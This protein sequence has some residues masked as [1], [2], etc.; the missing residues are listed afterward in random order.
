[1]KIAEL[2]NKKIAIIGFGVEGQAAA[3]FLRSRGLP[4]AILDKTAKLEIPDDAVRAELGEQYLANLSDYDVIIRSPGIQPF[5]PEFVEFKKRGGIIETQTRLFFDNYAHPERII[6]VTGTKGK[7]TTSILIQNILEQAKMPVRLAGN[8]GADMLALLNNETVAENPW[9]V[10]ELS[11]FQLQDCEASPHIA[12]VLMV[13]S[14][15]LDYHANIQEYVAA[16]ASIGRY[17]TP[18]D[19]I[20]INADYPSS[21][22]IGEESKAQKYLFST[23]TAA[24][25]GDQGATSLAE[26]GEIAFI[27]NGQ[28]V[29]LGKIS[30]LKLRGHHN[31]QNVCAAALV[32]SLVGVSDADIWNA[33]CD[34]AGYAHRLQLVHEENGVQFFDDSIA[35]VP[36]SSLTA[37]DSFP[38]PVILFVGGIDKGQDYENLGKELAARKSLKAVVA[39]GI[40]GKRIVN[41]LV[42]GGFSGK[43]ITPLEQDASAYDTA[44][45]E[46][47]TIVQAGDVV[48]LS[49]G[50]ASFDMFENYK[51]RGEYFTNLAKNFHLEG[52]NE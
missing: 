27:R 18:D 38:E 3:N 46:L 14:D 6:G 2:Q 22:M 32:G 7:G 33:C 47:Q 48:L 13:S 35:T 9:I 16:K 10:L 34:F 26:E 25:V 5:F 1:M 11:S 50:T 28:R 45:A 52:A 51:K 39:V 15:H 37:V 29:P 20:V 19:C 36:E 40:V 41:G 17:Q 4:F 21:L 42:S 31:T 44:F 43:I 49:P 30:E 12:V 8:I 23:V 24:I